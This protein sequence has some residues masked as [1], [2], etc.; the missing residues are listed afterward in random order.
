M[1]AMILPGINV[2][3]NGDEID[4]LD[5]NFTYEETKDP[6]GCI[7]SNRYRRWIRIEMLHNTKEIKSNG[8]SWH[9]SL[10]IESINALFYS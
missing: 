8:I 9:S 5:R 10:K 7:G 3:Y 2:I 1:L 4:M 6:I